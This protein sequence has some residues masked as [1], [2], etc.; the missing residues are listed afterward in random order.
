VKQRPAQIGSLGNAEN[1]GN[2][3]V[4]RAVKNERKGS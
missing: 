2:E 1:N 4:K 3:N